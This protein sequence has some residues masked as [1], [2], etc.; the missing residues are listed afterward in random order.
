MRKLQTVTLLLLTCGLVRAQERTFVYITGLT[1]HSARLA[2]GSTEGRG[3]TIGRQA[4]PL[5]RV[6]VEIDGRRMSE[7]ERSWTVI[8][9]LEPDR[10]YA[11]RV[12]LGERLLAQS[13]LRT[14]PL[15][16]RRVAFLVIGDYGK[17]N[18]T[19]S[20]LGQVM[21]RTLRSQEQEGNPVRFVLTT[22]DNI[23]GSFFYQRHTG[24]R[25]K[26]WHKRFFR[27]Y[28]ELL[29][30]VPFYPA[31]GNH[32]GSESERGDDLPVYLDNFFLPPPDSLEGSTGR[33]YAFTFA[34]LAQFWILDS[35]RHKGSEEGFIYRERGAQHQWLKAT[36]ATARLPW[37]VAV[38]HN[39]LYNA[40]PRY[41]DRDQRFDYVEALLG[42]SGVQVIFNGHEHN[43]QVSDPERTG[44]IRYIISGGGADTRDK[45]IVDDLEKHG[46]ALWSPEPH[47]LL[48]EIEGEDM[49]IT[50]LG[51]EGTP[52]QARTAEN[53]PLAARVL[54]PVSKPSQ[55]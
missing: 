5:G 7:E 49:Q 38:F 52:I 34:D 48:V 44:G 18:D 11:Y 36:L 26:D 20:R 25:D 30:R 31:L 40:G 51:Q 46:M 37:R 35:T 53:Q 13:T 4:R 17:G 22:G 55:R 21:F 28:R 23:Y 29:L 45:N 43:L 19:Q 14:S 39:P 1:S 24:K 47:F 9:G 50:A 54:I 12:R 15:K 16:A 8:E 32:D 42:E 6:E 10:P 41:E 27:P 33:Y 3:N 2:W